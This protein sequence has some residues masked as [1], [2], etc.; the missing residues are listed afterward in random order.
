MPGHISLTISGLSSDE[1]SGLLTSLSSMNIGTVGAAPVNFGQAGIPVGLTSVPPG[2]QVPQM[3]QSGNASSPPAM[4]PATRP[5]ALPGPATPPPPPAQAA[6]ASNPRLENVVKLMDA[7]A[8]AGHAV[9]G[10]RKVLGVLGLQRAQDAN[11]EQLVWLE[12]AFAN[13][14]WTP[15]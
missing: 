9:A 1:L 14:A 4:P 8:K 5:T 3:P 10:V 15:G 13:T 12:Q 11:E 2:Y 7:Y 6:P